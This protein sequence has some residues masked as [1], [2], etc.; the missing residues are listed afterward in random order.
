MATAHDENIRYLSGLSK[1]LDRLPLREVEAISGVLHQAY[2]S[3]HWTFVF[4]N[5]GSAALASHLVCDIGKGT[6]FPASSAA[7]LRS[8]KR[9]KILSLTDNV[10]MISAWANDASYE[11]V[12]AEQIE[13][14]ISPGDVAF[15]ISG[16]GNSANVLRA[17]EVARARSAKTVGLTGFE[18]GKMKAL[19]D[20]AAIAPASNM[21][22]IEDAHLI[23]THL[24]FLDLKRRIQSLGAPLA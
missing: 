17:L 6:H 21:Q 24:I 19:L 7:D 5:G 2:L 23:M 4:G 15:A 18:G 12:F 22:Q 1:V 14:Y 13:N 10:P 3:D 16:S 8:V 9:L 20:V 11:Q